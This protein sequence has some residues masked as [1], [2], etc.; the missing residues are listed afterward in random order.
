MLRAFGFGNGI[1]CGLDDTP[2][3]AC[4]E[5]ILRALLCR[6]DKAVV[7]DW[8]LDGSG[9]GICGGGGRARGVGVRIFVLL[10]VTDLEYPSTA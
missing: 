10:I 8:D 5:S 7:S 3:N 9:S 6:N 1:G 2:S 4:G